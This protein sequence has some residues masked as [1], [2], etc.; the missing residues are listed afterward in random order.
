MIRIE[1]L[2]AE[3]YHWFDG[4]CELK[5]SLF[6]ELRIAGYD[7]SE[8]EQIKLDNEVEGKSWIGR[9]M[10]GHEASVY[11]EV[12]PDGIQTLLDVIDTEFPFKREDVFVDLG[13]GTRHTHVY[14]MSLGHVMQALEKLLFMQHWQ[15]RVKKLSASSS[16]RH[17]TNTDCRLSKRPSLLPTVSRC[18]QCNCLPCVTFCPCV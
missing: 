3:L 15:H 7:C 2:I 17:A 14:F 12:L 16:V 10:T 4:T 11:G 13:S 18:L 6:V 9:F 8:T 1:Q 5:L